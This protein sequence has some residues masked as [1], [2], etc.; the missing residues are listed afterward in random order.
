MRRIGIPSLA[1][2]VLLAA[3][4]ARAADDA[5]AVLDRAIKAYGGAEK[6]AKMKTVQTKSKGTVEVAGGLSFT[7]ETQVQQPAQFKS[8][9]QLDV[10]GQTVTITTVFNKDKGWV[11]AA[12]QTKEL[13]GKALDETKELVYLMGLGRL[14]SLKDGKKYDVSL[15]G[16]DKVEGKPVVGIR[17]A[18]KGHKDVNLY[19][20]KDTGLIAKI[21]RQALD[22]TTGN[23]LQEERIIQEYQTVDG[24]PAAKKAVVNRDGKKFM[25]LEVQ[26]VKHLDSLDDSTFAKP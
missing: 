25:E 19:F 13:E 5:Q 21:T 7:E 9:T 16:D 6:L 20:A 15:V 23:E 14:T 3:G 8:V 2:L 4:L 10:N 1:A 12:G 11:Q 24:I 22:L 26:E 17:V 18:S